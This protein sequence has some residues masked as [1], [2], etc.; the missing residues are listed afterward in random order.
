MGRVSTGKEP[1]K[2]L[3]ARNDAKKQMLS[4]FKISEAKIKLSD[5]S[6]LIWMPLK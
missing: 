5:F 6:P 2:R 1:I 4:S 3:K